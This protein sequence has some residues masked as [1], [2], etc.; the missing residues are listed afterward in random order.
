MHVVLII[1]LKHFKI[2]PETRF[3][4]NKHFIQPQSTFYEHNA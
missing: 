4:V 2:Q 1:Q 3:Y